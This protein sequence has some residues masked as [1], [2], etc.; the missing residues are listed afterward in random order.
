MRWFSGAAV[1]LL[2]S[3][4]VLGGSHSWAQGASAALNTDE[5]AA[6]RKA[7]EERIRS[8]REDPEGYQRMMEEGRHRTTLCKT[9]HGVDGMAVRPNVPNLAGQN[10]VYIVDQFKRFGDGRRNDF[11]MS[12]LAKSFSEED[13]IKIALYYASLPMKSSA[14]GK[15]ELIGQGKRIFGNICSKC[16]GADGRGKE[17]YARLAGQRPDYVVKMLK[18]FRA[19]TGRRKNPWMTAVAVKL[20]DQDIEAVAAYVASIK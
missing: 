8:I 1:A 3:G 16:H 13:K 18:E 9:C 15:V 19:H 5:A 11:F 14:G 20:S 6:L 2:L 12:S 7:L 4:I 17:G 10:P